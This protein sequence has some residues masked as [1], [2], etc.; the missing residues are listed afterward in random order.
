MIADAWSATIRKILTASKNAWV[1]VRTFLSDLGARRDST[2]EPNENN[3]FNSTTI[4]FTQQEYQSYSSTDRYLT[5][6]ADFAS[7]YVRG[8]MAIAPRPSPED[9]PRTAPPAQ[10]TTLGVLVEEEEA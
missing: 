6:D 5:Y 7:S 4:Q 8:R 1:C 3:D 2:Q 10:S 9:R